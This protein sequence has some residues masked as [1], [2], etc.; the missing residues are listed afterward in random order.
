MVFVSYNL[1]DC[2]CLSQNQGGS[3]EVEQ[4]FPSTQR[5]DLQTA[6]SLD[7][8]EPSRIKGKQS[9]S[10]TEFVTSKCLFK[11]GCSP[12]EKKLTAEEG[13]EFWELEKAQNGRG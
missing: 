11:Y 9:Y 10:K 4:Q 6:N 2:R 7:G 12:K 13:L 1:K 3:C 5:E 8:E